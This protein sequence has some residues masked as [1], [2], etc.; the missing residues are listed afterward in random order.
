MSGPPPSDYG[1]ARERTDVY[2]GGPVPG[3]GGG[4]QYKR[5][6]DYQVWIFLFKSYLQ[7]FMS[8]KCST[9]TSSCC[10]VLHL[11]L[12]DLWLEKQAWNILSPC[13]E[14]AH[15]HP[16]LSLLPRSMESQC[17]WHLSVIKQPYHWQPI[18]NHILTNF[19]QT[20]CGVPLSV[21]IVHFFYSGY[22]K[23]NSKSFQKIRCKWWTM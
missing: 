6:P 10:L 7:G 12:P 5:P 8:F 18:G 19:N 16:I 23:F 17:P 11:P 2:N 9:M 15:W 22:K 14:L 13:I 1:P 20:F 21:R 4:H 3:Y